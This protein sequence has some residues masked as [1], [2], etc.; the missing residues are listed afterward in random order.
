MS[1]RL[2][3]ILQ[4]KYNSFVQDVSKYKWLA[5]TS[6]FPFSPSSISFPHP[7]LF[8][9]IFLAL[10]YL[11]LLLFSFFLSPPSPSSSFLT[12][13][14][15]N[16]YLFKISMQD[17]TTY[18]Y[19]TDKNMSWPGNVHNTSPFSPNVFL[20]ARCRQVEMFTPR[21]LHHIQRPN[22]TNGWHREGK[23]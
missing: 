17:V 11:P 4:P 20:C 1:V 23:Q 3:L 22:Y 21:L 16:L 12:F 9:S 15:H 7:P 5:N 8:F 13:P 6:A 2:P 14:S 10:H 19:T 18:K